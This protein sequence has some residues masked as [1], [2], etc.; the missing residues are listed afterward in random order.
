MGLCKA[1]SEVEQQQQQHVWLIKSKVNYD[2]LVDSTTEVNH[3][4]YPSTF[5]G[6]EQA[7]NTTV[8]LL[9]PTCLFLNYYGK[10]QFIEV[11]HH[12]K[13]P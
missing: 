1:S 7:H 4:M 10:E 8:T 11:K 9:L 5:S 6:S 13:L 12:Q 3:I 2:S